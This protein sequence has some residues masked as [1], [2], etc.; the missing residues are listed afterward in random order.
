[1]TPC[2]LVQH[3]TPASRLLDLGCI[4]HASYCARHDIEHVVSDRRYS[5]Q[6]PAWDKLAAVGEVLAN[7]PDGALVVSL[8]HDALVVSEN[9]LRSAPLGN[10]VVGAVRNV[11]GEF[12]TG[13]LFLRAC[14]AT[15]ELVRRAFV[16]GPQFAPGPHEHVALN[17]LLRQTRLPLA[18]L[19][20]RWNE[21][22]YADLVPPPDGPTVIRAWHHEERGVAAHQMS[23]VVAKLGGLTCSQV[24]SK[25][26]ISA[27]S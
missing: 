25:G 20:R 5:R 21:Y 7:A 11:H 4:R 2:Y 27:I 15:R 6:P 1:M 14:Q 3:C 23:C 18:V 19:S 16:D 22:R 17:L 24:R 12:N 10:A 8:D 13:V 9:D 26:S